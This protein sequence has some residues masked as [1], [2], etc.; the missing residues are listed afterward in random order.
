MTELAWQDETAARG[1]TRPP[2]GLV[3]WLGGTAL[4]W[5]LYTLVFRQTAGEPVGAAALDAVANVLP[6]ALLATATRALLIAHVMPRGVLVQ[7]GAH[8]GLAVAFATTWYALVLVALAF[9]TGVQGHGYRV[10]GFSGPAFT[11][12][13]FQGLVLYATVAAT[14]YAIRGGREAIDRKS[15]V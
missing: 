7:V 4:L 8:A 5:A 9:F 13:V 14:C 10:A 6:L 15:V 11:W 3:L 12:Q 1:A 2:S